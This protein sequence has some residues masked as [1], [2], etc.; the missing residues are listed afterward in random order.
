LPVKVATPATTR[1][2][3]GIHASNNQEALAFAHEWGFNHGEWFYVNGTERLYGLRG[4]IIFCIGKFHWHQHAR[5]IREQIL[6]RELPAIFI[7]EWRDSWKRPTVSAAR[8]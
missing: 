6:A 2:K 7:D 1:S 4:T 5:A 3:V 8:N